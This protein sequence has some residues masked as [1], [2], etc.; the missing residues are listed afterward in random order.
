MFNGMQSRELRHDK[1]SMKSIDGEVFGVP[2]ADVYRG[3]QKKGD[4]SGQSSQFEGWIHTLCLQRPEC[5]KVEAAVRR[6]VDERLRNP[7][8][9]F[10]AEFG[11]NTSVKQAY[12]KLFVYLRD[13]YQEQLLAS[14]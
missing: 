14:A 11:C 4:D 9:T 12:K 13:V 8:A 10:A 6:I 3:M 7:S 2:L 1:A 5:R